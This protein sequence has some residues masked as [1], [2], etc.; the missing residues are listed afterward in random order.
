GA[1]RALGRD[2][3][4]P[5]GHVPVLAG[6]GHAGGG[7]AGP[8]AG[9]GEAG[10]AR[11]AHGRAA[12]DLAG[13]ERGPGRARADGAGRSGGDP[14]GSVPGAGAGR[15]RRRGAGPGS[16]GRGRD[17][18]DGAAGTGSGRGRAGPRRGGR[19]PR[20]IHP[21][22]DHGGTGVRP[23]GR[24]SDGIGGGRR[25]RS[26]SG[27][28]YQ[29]ALARIP[30]GVNS[31]VRAFR[32]AGG[33]P[34]FVAR[35]AGARLEDVDGNTYVDYVLSWGALRAGHAEPDIVRAIAAAAERGTSYGTPCPVEVELAELVASAVP[36]VE[37]LR[38]VNS[39]TE[40]TMSAIRVARGATGRDV[41]VKF[42]GCYHGHAD[43][44]LVQAGSGVATL[45]LPDSPGVPRALAELTVTVP[46]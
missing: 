46:F 13:A 42:A 9:V 5:R 1:A 12:G 8:G 35:A 39:G 18:A 40:A 38:F 45:G 32:A 34:I 16:A 43:S 17:R 23:G 22:P 28:L 29:R 14:G 4:R 33:D 31:P 3:V 41:I 20:R 21:G 19:A 25:V 15:R 27:R 44:F 26:E 30:G 6:G 24:A 2:R 10:A 11:G 36:S 7:D 37:M